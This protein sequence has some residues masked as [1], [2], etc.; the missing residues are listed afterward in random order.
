MN[1]KGRPRIENIFVD[2][3]E[4]KHCGGEHGCGEYLSLGE[5]YRSSAACDGLQTYCKKCNSGYLR[6]R[7]KNNPEKLRDAF[8]F[9]TYGINL[10]EYN[11]LLKS[12]NGV[13]RMCHQPEM[14][15]GKFL[16]V[17]HVHDSD[18][19]V[20]RGLLCMSCNRLLGYAKHSAVILSSAIDYLESHQ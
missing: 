17:D 11:V 7:R 12:Q 4:L 13:C 1:K 2:G 19:I 15:E 8:L 3:Q 16:A 5:F 10:E 20:V 18:P 6:Q 14:K 9:K